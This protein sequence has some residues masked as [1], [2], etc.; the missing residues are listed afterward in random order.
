MYA[1]ER[2][3]VAPGG[4]TVCK[5]DQCPFLQEDLSFVNSKAGLGLEFNTFE[6]SNQDALLTHFASE[7]RLCCQ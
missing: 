5:V 3:K 2:V 1:S 7:L 4:F 6:Q